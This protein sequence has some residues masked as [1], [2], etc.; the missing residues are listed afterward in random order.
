MRQ[1]LPDTPFTRPE[2]LAA[3]VTQRQWRMLR[4]ERQLREIVRDVFVDASLPDTLDLRLAAVARTLTP[5]QV[6]AR[7]TAA[8][9]SG[10][11]VLDSRGL[12]ATPRVEVVVLEQSARPK[13]RLVRAHSADDLRASDVVELGGIPVTSPLRTATDLA[14][15]ARRGDALVALDWFL[16]QGSFTRAELLDAVSRWRARRGVQQLRELAAIANPGSESGGESR[17]RLLVIDGGL[18]VPELQIWIVDHAGRRR[19]RLD[20][21]YRDRRI[22]LEFDGTEFHGPEREAHDVARRR[23]I[24]ARG[25]IVLVFRSDDV[26]VTPQATLDRIAAAIR[27]CK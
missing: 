8:W 22:G 7:T 13:G 25:W 6:V 5:G 12:P 17:L 19:Y 24:E 2:L 21:G 3:G 27:T 18:P 16:R 4:D 26:F 14:R 20:L 11:D 1:M 15:F 10:L 23:W 9:I